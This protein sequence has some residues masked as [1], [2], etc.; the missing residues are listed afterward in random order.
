MIRLPSIRA[1][2]SVAKSIG[3]SV[4]RKQSD[5]LILSDLPQSLRSHIS[6]Q[7]LDV[8][9]INGVYLSENKR[10]LI[11]LQTTE[12]EEQDQMF[13]DELQHLPNEKEL[14]VRV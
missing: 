14:Y 8:L 11:K 1:A 12:D 4:T 3:C 2:L 7:L 9:T 6:R 13:S 5:S 10:V